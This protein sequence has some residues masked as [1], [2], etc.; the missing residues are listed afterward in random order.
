VKIFLISGNVN[1]VAYEKDSADAMHH[2]YEYDADN[3]ITQVETSI[4]GVLWD[5]DAKYFYY[6]HGPLARTEL[7]NE[8]V[9]GMDYAYTLQGWI[10]GVNSNTLDTTRDIGQ[11]GNSLLGGNPNAG[12]APDVMGYTL[13]YFNGDYAAIDGTHWTSATDRFEADKVPFSDLLMGRNDLFNGNITAMVT[14]ITDPSSRA[15]LPQGMAYNYDQ[16]NR[17]IYAKGYT[18][19]DAVNNEWEILTQSGDI[20][21]NLFM[22][23]ANGNITAQYRAD[24]TGT[25]IDA[26]TYNYAMS[27]GEL[28]QNRLYH[29]ND[30]IVGSTPTDDIEDQGTFTA[31]LATINSANNYEYDAEGRLAKDMQEE[32]DT[33]IWTVTGKVKEVLRTGGSSKKNIK[34]DY[35]A[36]GM[37]VAK[38]IFDA[39]NTWE[40]STYYVRGPQGNVMATYEE[41]VVSMLTHFKLKE[42]DIYG[43]SRLGMNTEEVEMIG[44]VISDTN[45]T[46]N[47]GL[48]YYE[49]SNHLRNV[50]TVVSDKLLPIDW[51]V[52]GTVDCYKADI[53]STSDYY[54]FGA[55]MAGRTFS[56]P[57]YRYAFNGKEKDDEVSVDG[58]DYDFGAR[59]Y[60]SRLGRWMSIDPSASK[61]PNQSPYNFANNSA[62]IIID[63]DGKES[64]VIAGGVDIGHDDADQYKFI[65]SALGHV[66]RGGTMLLMTANMTQDQVLEVQRSVAA[67]NAGG[68][69][70][71]TLVIAN[72]SQEVVNYLNS[73]STS[74]TAVSED[75]KDDKITDVAVYGHGLTGSLAIG[76]PDKTPEQKKYDITTKE[77]D[78]ISSADFADGATIDLYNCNTATGGDGITNMA[79][80]ISQKTQTTVT[81]YEGKTDYMGIYGLAN[82][83][84]KY[85]GSKIVPAE[86][87]PAPGTKKDQKT[88]SVKHT[89]TDGKEVPNK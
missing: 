58:G 9:Q 11:D 22:Y 87:Q 10:K 26:L 78:Q 21:A 48:K 2:R 85:I 7:G 17:L 71:V 56:S 3:R 51:N 20:D 70:N 30:A 31:A 86:N 57:S 65:N 75:R 42:R 66:E 81:G 89:Y 49:M 40:K 13:N 76:Y 46:H 77:V 35:D 74:T 6:A 38:H 80:Y 37:R 64:I 63:P 15:I 4:D 67:L 18:N 19:L 36:F 44:A 59:I 28:V 60:D 27:G 62:I 54:P 41:T 45:A 33:I 16:L 50:I 24:E 88:P 72:S 43:S 1:T 79:Q 29:V 34:F 55:P 14:T 47:I 8:H 68:D 39:S 23:D 53:V 84:C 73:K 82:R 32:I 83:A 52:D 12:F 25:L 5:K 61:F 69:M